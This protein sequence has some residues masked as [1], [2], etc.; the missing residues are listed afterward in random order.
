MKKTALCILS[1][2]LICALLGCGINFATHPTTEAPAETTAPVEDPTVSTTEET[3]VTTPPATEETEP[4]N[5]LPYLQKILRADQSIYDS[6]SYDGGFVGTVEAAGT[7]TIVE[8][9]TDDEGNLWGKLKSG[10]GWVDLTEIRSFEAAPKPLTANFA[11]ETLLQSGNYHYYIAQDAE[12]TVSIAFRAT[13]Q[14]TDVTLYAMVLNETMERDAELYTLDTLTPEKPFVADLE[15]P[16]DMSTYEIQFTDA[17]GKVVSY[18]L[19][20]SGRNGSLV[21]SEAKS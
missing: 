10:L 20:I 5:A 12:F 1:W 15:F 11:D 2:L 16:G 13:E 21:L 3:V 18:T 9:A 14:L 19:S 6:P 8:E 17:G 4:T 7:Y